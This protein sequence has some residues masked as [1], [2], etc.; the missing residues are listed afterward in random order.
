MKNNKD[1]YYVSYNGSNIKDLR[2]DKLYDEL[3]ISYYKLKAGDSIDLSKYIGT[4]YKLEKNWNENAYTYNSAKNII[5]TK[6]IKDVN[7]ASL[8]LSKGKKKY[9]IYFSYSY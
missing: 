8:T 9:Q 6:K 5:K 7:D 1:L 2:F 3:F 4:G